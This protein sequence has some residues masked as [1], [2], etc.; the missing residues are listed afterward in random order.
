MFIDGQNSGT[1]R[2]EIRLKNWLRKTACR[3]RT[4]IL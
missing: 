4:S 3:W 1:K 2:A